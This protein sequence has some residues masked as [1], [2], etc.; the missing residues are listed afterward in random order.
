MIARFRSSRLLSGGRNRRF[1]ACVACQPQR[2]QSGGL[3]S[4]GR[5]R[6]RVFS[7][8]LLPLLQL[9]FLFLE[10]RFGAI[11]RPFSF[12]VQSDTPSR[13]AN[14]LAGQTS[15]PEGPDAACRC[16]DAQPSV[17]RSRYFVPHPP[18][19]RPDSFCCTACARV[20]QRHARGHSVRSKER[21]RAPPPRDP[22]LLNCREG[23][24]KP[25]P[26]N[27]ALIRCK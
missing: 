10:S 19:G 9:L 3:F 18:I 21:V 16:W 14:P 24:S 11:T 2:P 6:C 17:R 13:R 4:R 25:V 15:L 20:P 1:Q 5:T 26:I 12:G 22:N 27:F 8:C 23:V 7:H